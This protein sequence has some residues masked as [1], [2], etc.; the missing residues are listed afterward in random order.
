[1]FVAARA[2]VAPD[3]QR[4]THTNLGACVSFN[5]ADVAERWMSR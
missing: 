4:T 5:E 1:M 3:G 2:V